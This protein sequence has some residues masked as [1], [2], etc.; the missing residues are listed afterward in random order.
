MDAASTVATPPPYSGHYHPNPPRYCFCRCHHD[1]HLTKLLVTLTAA[2][3]PLQPSRA[4]TRPSAPLARCDS[5]NTERP[6][7][8]SNGALRNATKKE[9]KANAPCTPERRK[10]ESDGIC[11]AICTIHSF[12]AVILELERLSAVSLGKGASDTN[13]CANRST[14][15]ARTPFRP[16]VCRITAR[17]R[18]C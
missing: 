18:P 9:T 2:P 1:L 3:L 16:C 13:F 7:V 15:R 17:V 11:P 6:R 8:R 5:L 14:L 4:N 12:R 10:G